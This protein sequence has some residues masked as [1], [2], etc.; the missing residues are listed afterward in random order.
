MMHKICQNVEDTTRNKTNLR[1][2]LLAHPALDCRLGK[3][4]VWG[5]T[6]QTAVLK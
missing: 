4:K 1:G 3:E 2:L 6:K 5:Q